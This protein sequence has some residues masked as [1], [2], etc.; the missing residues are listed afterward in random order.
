[1]VYD[2]L[3]YLATEMSQKE[4]LENFPLKSALFVR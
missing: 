2:V 4:I 1:M 3:K